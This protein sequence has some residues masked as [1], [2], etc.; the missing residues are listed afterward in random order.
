MTRG[1]DTALDTAAC[2]DTGQ[3][4]PFTSLLAHYLKRFK[5]F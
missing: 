2:V 3:E 5:V 1:G 4:E